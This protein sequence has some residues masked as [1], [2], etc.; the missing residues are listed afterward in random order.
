MLAI[1][2]FYFYGFPEKYEKKFQRLV[3]SL[4]FSFLVLLENPFCLKEILNTKVLPSTPN[5]IFILQG[6]IIH[7]IEWNPLTVITNNINQTIP[8]LQ[9]L[10]I[11]I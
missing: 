9:T 6:C 1:M 5:T 8:I 4:F 3:L 11:I 10:I 7:R 2:R